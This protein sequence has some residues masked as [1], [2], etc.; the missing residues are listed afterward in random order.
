MA[1]IFITAMAFN[2]S[3]QTSDSKNLSVAPDLRISKISIKNGPKVGTCNQI[4]VT[5]ANNTQSVIRQKVKIIISVDQPRFGRKIYEG[6]IE[7]AIQPGNNTSNQVWFKN[8]VLDSSNL[9][10]VKAI[11]N[12]DHKIME[13]DYN[14]NQKIYKADVTKFCFQLFRHLQKSNRFK[15]DECSQSQNDSQPSLVL[16]KKNNQTNHLQFA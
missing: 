13:S 5:I 16:K 8:V 2:G 4:L 3:F 9:V 14:N 11:I 12:P 7:N 6:Y 15:R 1:S 10:T